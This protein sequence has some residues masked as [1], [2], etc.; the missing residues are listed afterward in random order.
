[1]IQLIEAP[2]RSGK[3]YY[4]VNYLSKFWEYD[5][6]YSEYVLDSN[7]LVISNVEGLKVRHW[8][9][10]ECLKNRSLEEFF[11]IENF[12][13]IM[14]KTGKSHIILG[15]DECHEIFPANV[16]VKS[17]PKLYEFFAYHGHIG[18][19]IFLMTQGIESTSRLFLPLLEFIV[20]VKP[21]SEKLYKVFSYHFFSKT[22]SKLYSKNIKNDPLI[23]GA[24]KSF[25]KDENNK[26]KSALF[27]ALVFA[28]SMCLIG[29]GLF[30][31]TVHGMM[32]KSDDVLPVPTGQPFQQV[33]NEQP[34]ETEVIVDS[35][36]PVD[37]NLKWRLYYLEGFLRKGD[38]LWYI[39]NGQSMKH[40][41]NFRNFSDVSRTVEYYGQ[42]LSEPGRQLP[43]K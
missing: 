38:T 43:S 37:D 15:I 7:V 19:D 12:E 34:P 3:T 17:H 32:N 9:L 31:Y 5:G 4:F 40:T 11:S 1:M 2:P 20:K 36:A 42:E 23:F 33:V 26:P 10:N 6:L 16:T 14:E 39:I 22:G 18:L 27:R 21:R 41:S 28:C 30:S 24:Y 8:D 29:V 25:R 13:K 35:T